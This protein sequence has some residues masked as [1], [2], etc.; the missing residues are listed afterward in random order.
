MI[1]IKSRQSHLYKFNTIP[2]FLQI[3]NKIVNFIT[4]NNLS[5]NVSRSESF[6]EL[7]DAISERNVV[8]PGTKSFLDSLRDQFDDQKKLSYHIFP[9]N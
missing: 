9:Q 6:R 7:L 4:E 2:I 8:V 1:F 3:R 5:F